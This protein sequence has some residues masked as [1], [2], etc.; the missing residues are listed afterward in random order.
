MAKAHERLEMLARKA[1]GVMDELMDDLKFPTT[2]FQA[3]RFAYEQQHGRPT[4]RVDMRLSGA[5]GL[6]DRIAAVRKRLGETRP[7]PQNP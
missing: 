6:H 4:E 7:N 1:L 2:R 3:A 5:V